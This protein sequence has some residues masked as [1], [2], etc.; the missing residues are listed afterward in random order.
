MSKEAASSAKR[1]LGAG[2]V[3]NFSQGLPWTKAREAMW[4]TS[5]LYD[6]GKVKTPTLI[7]VGARDERVP[8]QHARALF[9]ALDQYLDVP[10]ELVEYPREP[11][12]LGQREH[13]AAKMAWDQAWLDEHVLGQ[14]T[15]KK[16][17]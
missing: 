2:H 11:H 7:H 6:L 3:V 17:R 15:G 13:R 12:G 4:R 5:P 1:E 14:S 8:P 9:R 16:T 10:T